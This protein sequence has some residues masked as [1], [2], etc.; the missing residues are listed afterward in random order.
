MLG[1]KKGIQPVSCIIKGSHL[2][3]VEEEDQGGRPRAIMLTQVHPE[4]D[5]Q[6]GRDGGGPGDYNSE[7]ERRTV[8][9]A[10]L[11]FLVVETATSASC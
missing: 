1:G 11:S 5:R 10:F 7:K 8:T 4:N 2:Q 3:Q 9:G 6:N